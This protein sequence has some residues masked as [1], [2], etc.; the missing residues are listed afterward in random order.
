MP[1]FAVAF[2]HY[3]FIYFNRQ[4]WTS[5]ILITVLMFKAHESESASAESTNLV[6]VKTL[7]TRCL[8]QGSGIA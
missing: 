7:S 5:E 4:N 8:K 6:N 1:Y 2:V 3:L